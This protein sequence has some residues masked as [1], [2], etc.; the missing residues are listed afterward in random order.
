ME[1]PLTEMGRI[2]FLTGFLSLAYKRRLTNIKIYA[3]NQ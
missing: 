2:D 1:L 3:G